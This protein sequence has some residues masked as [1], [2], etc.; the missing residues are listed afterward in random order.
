MNPPQPPSPSGPPASRFVAIWVPDWPVVALTM[1]ARQQHR[2]PRARQ[3]AP[4]LPDPATEPVAVVGARGVLAASAPARRAGITT[5]MRL[6]AARSLCP[7]LTVLP[8]QEE[9]QARAF[10]TVMEALTSLLADPMVA[11]PGLAL[12]HARGPAAWIGGEE[13]LAS[14]L[15]ETV[16][17]EADVE[18][19]VGIADSLPGA[20]LAARQGII[21][22]PGRTPEFLAPWP[23]DALL[24]CLPRS[25]LRRDAR[26][27]L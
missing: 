5:G 6:R 23:L 25:R 2:H 26:P 14:A 20:V 24:T 17:Q 12:S 10:E 15:V 4:H 27:M 22:E 11:R 8:P 1:E 13:L 3:G 21:V 9:R 19:Q 18:C 7:E 16:T